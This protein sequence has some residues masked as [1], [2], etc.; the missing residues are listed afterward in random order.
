MMIK[1]EIFV[2]SGAV[3]DER[4]R[5]KEFLT[6]PDVAT[7]IKRAEEIFNAGQVER[8]AV[9]NKGKIIRVFETEGS[10]L[11]LGNIVSMEEDNQSKKRDRDL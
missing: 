5:T 9:H 3:L 4:F 8:V 7:A 2:K 11:G 10:I 6:F 1:L